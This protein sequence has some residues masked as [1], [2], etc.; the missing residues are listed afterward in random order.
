MKSAQRTIGAIALVTISTCGITNSAHAATFGSP[1]ATKSG[2]MF[3]MNQGTAYGNMGVTTN[4]KNTKTI[5]FNNLNGNKTGFSTGFATYSFE[6]SSGSSSVR[7]DRWVPENIDRTENWNNPYLAVFTGDKVTIS[8]FDNKNHP[9]TANYFGMNWGSVSQ[10]NRIEFFNGDRLVGAYQSAGNNVNQLVDGQSQLNS[11]WQ[12]VKASETKAVQDAQVELTTAK[13]ELTTAKQDLTSTQRD[14]T[15]AQRDLTSIQRD[16]TN[17]QRELTAAKAATQVN[18]VKIN[19][20]VAK[21]ESLTTKVTDQQV[22]TATLTTNVAALTTKV[23]VD[24]PLNI[25]QKENLVREKQ[26]LVHPARNFWNEADAYTE[27]WASDSKSLFNKIVLTQVNNVGGGFE[28]DNHSF[29]LGSKA[30]NPT[31][32]KT[33]TVPEP[34]MV[35]GLMGVGSLLLKNKPQ[36]QKPQKYSDPK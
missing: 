34:G 20:L 35:V 12:A 22:K 8:L 26:K 29:L 16:L 23:K 15:S 31:T 27:F 36:K 30:F 18:T 5:D 25:K 21:V 24:L 13:A 17:A 6:R 9:T 33:E 28:T 7:A 2:V 10:N 4:V 3:R 1:N 19:G 32:N 11:A 14:L